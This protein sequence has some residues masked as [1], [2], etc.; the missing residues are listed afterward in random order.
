MNE[1]Y[2]SA[3]V[4]TTF[5]WNLKTQ[6]KRETNLK[7]HNRFL[8]FIIKRR[9]RNHFAIDFVKEQMI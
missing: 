9:I 4:D 7:C 3:E 1:Q 6:S 2:F 8:S 5:K